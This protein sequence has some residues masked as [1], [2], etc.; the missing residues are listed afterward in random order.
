LG[1]NPD[2]GQLFAMQV[3]G[4]GLH[5]LTHVRGTV[6]EADG[7]VTVELLGPWVYVYH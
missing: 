7:T 5:Q 3:D 6:T 1:T 2:G 4:T